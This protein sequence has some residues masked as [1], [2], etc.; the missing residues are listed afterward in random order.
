MQRLAFVTEADVAVRAG[1]GVLDA[2]P[3]IRRRR[4]IGVSASADEAVKT[5][6]SAVIRQLL[7][8]VF[9]SDFLRRKAHRW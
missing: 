7:R 6:M 8:V 2:L 4:R 1:A 3:A 5:T 9:M